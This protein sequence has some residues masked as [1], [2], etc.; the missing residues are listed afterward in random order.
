MFKKYLKRFVSS[1]F[2]IEIYKDF[3]DQQ[4]VDFLKCYEN[5]FHRKFDKCEFEW[6]FEKENYFTVL[7]D[8]RNLSIGLYGLLSINLNINKKEFNSYLCHN[9]GIIDEYGGQG[10]FQFIGE[11]AISNVVYGNELVLG[12][13]NKASRK[14]HLRLGWDQIGDIRFII[15]KGKDV[16]YQSSNYDFVSIEEF[17]EKYEKAF[18]TFS[19]KFSLSLNKTIKYL[20]WRITKPKKTY[21]IYLIQ[22]DGELKG[23]CIYKSFSDKGRK[24]LHIVDYLFDDMDT[25]DEIIRFSIAKKSKDSYDVLNTWIV[26][27]T[28]Y[29]EH[30]F[31][32][33]F[34]IEEEMSDYPVI[35]FQKNNYVNFDLI[36]KQKIFFTLFDNDV[37]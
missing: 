5:I 23:Y 27:D 28:I 18:T 4:W 1:E 24:K 36:D 10:L 3:T 31:E 15:F 30:F 8:K 14:G 11:K 6:Y 20:N 35:L 34:V 29:E 16:N 2:N 19:Q 7:K 12:F 13:P 33:E 26:K 17:D 25:L 21:M 22:K 32:H 37:F 9:V